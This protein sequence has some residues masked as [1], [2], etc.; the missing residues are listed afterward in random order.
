MEV[1][2]MAHT[3]VSMTLFLIILATWIAK[4]EVVQSFS[5]I[6]ACGKSFHLGEEPRGLNSSSTARICQ[7]LRGVCFYATLY[8][9]N[10]RIPIYSAYI[11]EQS[12]TS[13]PDIS[14]SNWYLEPMLAGIEK[15]DMQ[16][17]STSLVQNNLEQFEES[18]AVNNDY[19]NSGLTRGHLNPSQHHSS[20]AQIATFTYT[21]MAPKESKLNSG[22]WNQYENFL[23]SSILPSCSETHVVTGV[24]PSGAT[25]QQGVWI[26]GRVNVPSFF[27]SAFFC[28]L[29]NGGWRTEARLGRN[30]SPFDVQTKTVAELEE[31]LAA[32]FGEDVTIFPGE[33][34]SE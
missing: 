27:W 7:R 34:S 15:P 10:A 30:A 19:R 2:I 26:H 5:E 4:G 21:N 31:I 33:N 13:R 18:Q 14:S 20:E 28:Q 11:L 16:Q 8:D 22:S 32:Q 3:F 23:R 12:T 17:A 9:Q 25:V 6:P 29:K 1:Q 24:I